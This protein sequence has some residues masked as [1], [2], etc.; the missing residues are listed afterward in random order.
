MQQF[1]LVDATKLYAKGTFSAKNDEVA[2]MGQICMWAALLAFLMLRATH[3]VY[4][5]GQVMLNLKAMSIICPKR[6][7]VKV[8]R[9]MYFAMSAW[10]IN[11]VSKIAKK[12]KTSQKSAS[13]P[14]CDL[15]SS[16]PAK[17]AA[18]KNRIPQKISARNIP[19]FS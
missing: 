4:D 12:T 9:R 14:R 7:R 2:K 1:C 16:A 11:T 18:N 17:P 15:L 13:T 19:P 6:L 8:Y 10:V 5:C 3:L